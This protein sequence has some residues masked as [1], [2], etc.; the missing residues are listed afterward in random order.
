[1]EQPLVVFF[2]NVLDIGVKLL[3]VWL[4]TKINHDINFLTRIYSNLS[5]SIDVIENIKTICWSRS[6]CL[7][8]IEI[9]SL[10][11]S[12]GILSSTVMIIT[13][14]LSVAA[15][16][17]LGTTCLQVPSLVKSLRG[18]IAE[19]SEVLKI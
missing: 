13:W 12:L 6:S 11:F 10:A 5:S 9:N 19:I 1:M 7:L 3:D 16:K 15:L 8:N 17:T 14:V 4:A 2:N 18:I